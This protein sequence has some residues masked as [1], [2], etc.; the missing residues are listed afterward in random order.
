M[1][2][3][4]VRVAVRVRPLLPKEV[5]HN[6]KVCVRVVPDSTQVM[7]GT[8]RAFSFDHAFG[9]TASQDDVYESCVRPLVESLV[10]GY[11]A[12]VFAYGQTGSGK[13]YTLRGGHVASLLDEQGGIIDRVAQDVFLL[14]GQKKQNGA[15]QTTVRVSYIELHREELRDLLELHTNHKELHIRED[16][17]GNTVVMGAK[18]VIV[19]SAEEF[20]SITDAGNALRHTGTTGMNEHSSRSHAIL[21]MQLTQ[22]CHDSGS[23]LNTAC[24]SKLHLVDLAGSERAGKTGNTGTRLKESV[25]INTGLLALSNVIRALSDSG[26]S[27]R[28][29]N[30]NITHIPYRNA[31]ITRLLRDSLGGTAHTLMVAC[32]SPS[33]HSL[34]ETLNVLQ[35]AATARHIRNRPGAVCSRTETKSCSTTWDPGK[36]RLEELEHEA[37]MLR[38]L[39]KEKE[40]ELR[41]EREQTGDR[42]VGEESLKHT[43]QMMTPHK[44]S[45]P[46]RRLNPE[47]LSEYRFLAQDAAALFEDISSPTLCP[48]L[49]QRLQDWQERLMAVSHSDQNDDGDEHHHVTILQLRRELSKCQETLAIDEQVL[50]QKDEEL[51]QLQKEIDKLHEEC[52]TH[53]QSLEEERERTRIQ[54]EQLVDQQ[55]LINRL[56]SNVMTF[57]G[58]TSGASEEAG[59]SGSSARRP[60]SVPLIRHSCGHGPVRKIHTSPPAHSLERV[61]AAFKMRSHLLLAEIEEKDKVYC[62][63][64]KQQEEESDGEGRMEISCSLNH[65]WTS[66]QRRAAQSSKME[67]QSAQ[68][69]LVDPGAEETHAK[70]Y[71]LRRARLRASVIQR[72]IQDLSV[73]M[74]MKEEL[75]KELHKTGKETQAVNRPGRLRG[76]GRDTDVLA[77]LSLQSQQAQAELHHSLQHMRQQRA[78]LQTSL[79]QERETSYATKEVDQNGLRAEHLT[80]WK[81]RFEDSGE[82]EHN[83]TWLEVEE[84][85]ALQKRQELQELE[86]ELRTKEEVL[87]RR[88]ACLQQRNSL[89]IKK[90][91]SSQALNQDLLHV[92]VRLQSVEEELV[93]SNRAGR[94]GGITT[95]DLEKERE[96]L[97]EKRDALDAQL[98]D[99]RVL[100]AQEEYS[101]LQL[102]EA[103][104]VL[105]AA[106]EFKNRSIQDKQKQLSVTTSSCQS[107]NT[108]PAH[109]CNVIRK[110]NDLSPSEATELLVKYFNKVVCLRETERRLQLHCEE[111]QLQVEEQEVVLREMENALQC[112]ALDTDR[113]LIQQHRDHQSSIQLLLRQLKEGGSGETEQAIH[114]R[115]HQLEKE[116]FFYKSSTRQLKK[117]L[118]ELLSDSLQSGA[119]PSHTQT[120]THPS[121]T[122]THNIQI[123]SKPTDC[124]THTE[125]I[126]T[127]AHTEKTYNKLHTEQIHKKTHTDQAKTSQIQTPTER[128][129]HQ[130]SCASYSFNLQT[131]KKAKVSAFTHPHSH[132]QSQ[133]GGLGHSGDGSEMTPV[134][135]SRRE[136]RQ[137]HPA[138]LQVCGSATRR[139][140]SVL[141]TSTETLLEDSIEMS[142]STNR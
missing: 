114:E 71:D 60:H 47:D 127:K 62:P 29:N 96:A 85:Q 49:R 42:V 37:H 101:M 91:R 13:T 70:Q 31:K 54:T 128:H 3:V 140:N 81:R 104:E 120:Q 65:T 56:R 21:T 118:K 19:T 14:L 41:S 34:T 109:L 52:K 103:I 88:E 113:R 102:E 36:A 46:D 24:S 17:R 44:I 32:V 40:R 82:K 117:K 124:Q 84:E 108:E 35:F 26:R 53:L 125:Q 126:Q 136:L 77:R 106:L 9:P 67:T 57:R 58:A 78:Q 93:S 121:S 11:N 5:L 131:Q 38:E 142:R 20:L 119:Q 87:Q 61:L 68:H 138:E 86:E 69:S 111:L 107:N 75:I 12:T 89:R 59:N 76:N 51:T 4:C 50:E 134:R 8:E 25:Y 112:L 74:R 122:E 137:I 63:F 79:R 135:L 18:E 55:I 129:V 22:H 28:G 27:R 116:L 132:Q 6:H 98:K 94:G 97:R 43:S 23:S 39:L 45:D 139:R 115:I 7:V 133:E 66:R 95:E 83:T 105:D 72:R 141:D 64:T 1:N 30:S 130:N 123:Y 99:N 90:L 73:N 80:V 15:A 2:E 16:D 10:E 110:L 48:S 92:S 100:T 33:H